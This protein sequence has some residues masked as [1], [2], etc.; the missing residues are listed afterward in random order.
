MATR[1]IASIVRLILVALL[2]TGMA[3]LPPS[4]ERDHGSMTV[5]AEHSDALI[6]GAAA[7]EIASVHPGTADFEKAGI[8]HAIGHDATDHVHATA[9]PVGWSSCLPVV[10]ASD[11]KRHADD[12]PASNAT[13]APDKPPKSTIVT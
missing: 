13:R 2:V 12:R 1:K 8:G 5:S 11:W 10:V 4:V 6:V 3:F 7:V 9:L